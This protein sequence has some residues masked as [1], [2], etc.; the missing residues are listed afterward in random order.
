MEDEGKTLKA[1][2]AKSKIAEQMER[3][4]DMAQVII[5]WF[6]GCFFDH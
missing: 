3:Y 1:I 6:V 5:W 2:L 4:K